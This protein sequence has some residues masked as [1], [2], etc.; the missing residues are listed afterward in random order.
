MVSVLGL[1]V[2]IVLIKGLGIIIL[3]KLVVVLLF[4]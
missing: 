3:L 2:L 4:V 1:F